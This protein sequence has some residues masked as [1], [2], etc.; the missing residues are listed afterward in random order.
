LTKD[1]ITIGRVPHAADT[2]RM[3][4]ELLRTLVHP[5]IETGLATL[6]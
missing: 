3:R 4:R 6:V 2:T 5:T 1:F